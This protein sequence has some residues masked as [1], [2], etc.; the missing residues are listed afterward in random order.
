[1]ADRRLTRASPSLVMIDGVIT[2]TSPTLQVWWA[3]TTGREYGP[4]RLAWTPTITGLA[5]GAPHRHTLTPPA[6]G[7]GCVALIP[8]GK[9]D[10]AIIIAHH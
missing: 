1:M 8:D 6:S 7:T 4:A 5:V 10:R 3:D 9:R 2:R